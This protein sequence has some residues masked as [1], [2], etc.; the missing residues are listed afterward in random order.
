MVSSPREQDL[1]IRNSFTILEVNVAIEPSY[2]ERKR[3]KTWA[4]GGLQDA[5]WAFYKQGTVFK[6]EK[7]LRHIFFSPDLLIR[8]FPVPFK[9]CLIRLS[10]NDP[11]GTQI[12]PLGSWLN[13]TSSLPPFL[14][15]LMHDFPQHFWRLRKVLHFHYVPVVPRSMSVSDNKHI[16]LLLTVGVFGDSGC[17]R[18]H[19]EPSFYFTFP[20][21]GKG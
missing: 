19:R 21:E 11:Y 1:A 12:G 18:I 16:S 4:V 6:F 17:E 14:L 3:K 10:E 2:W 15:L 7:A 8:N 5:P 9:G 20:R 13:F